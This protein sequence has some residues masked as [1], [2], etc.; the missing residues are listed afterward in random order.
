M[1]RGGLEEFMKNPFIALYAEPITPLKHPDS[2]LK[3]LL[4]ASEKGGNDD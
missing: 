4:F 2:S 3:K 1:V